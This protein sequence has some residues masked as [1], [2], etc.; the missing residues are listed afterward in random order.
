MCLGLIHIEFSQVTVTTSPFGISPKASTQAI[1]LVETFPILGWLQSLLAPRQI[2][3]SQHLSQLLK[4]F[5]K[6]I[7]F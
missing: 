7:I 4:S 1:R 2:K 3:Q 6:L 5:F